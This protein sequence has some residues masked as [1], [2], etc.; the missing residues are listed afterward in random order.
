MNEL[1]D[2]IEFLEANCDF[3]IV[4]D[5]KWAD[6]DFARFTEL[7]GLVIPDQLAEMLRQYGQCGTEYNDS[8]LVEYEDGVRSVHDIQVLISNF[9]NIV[10]RHETFFSASVWEKQF[11]LPMV[12]FGSADSGH[13][14][15]LMDGENPKNGAVYFW[16][17]ATDP[18]G[19]GNNAKGVVK[20]ADSLPEFLF[21]L[22]APE[23]L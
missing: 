1:K 11:T 12:F 21:S 13:S 20:L 3:Q 18:F 14:Y 9:D 16:E 2:A 15:L 17:R 4:P 8:F 6:S 19:T 22:S 23:N 7:T 10:S 5:T